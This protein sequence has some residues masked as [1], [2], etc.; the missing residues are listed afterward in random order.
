LFVRINEAAKLRFLCEIGCFSAKFPVFSFRF[1]FFVILQPQN[2]GKGMKNLCNILNINKLS[3]NSGGVNLL[4]E[5]S[6]TLSPRQAGM[7][8]FG[9]FFVPGGQTP[10]IFESLNLKSLNNTKSLN[11]N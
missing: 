2:R 4:S 1:V 11:L 3:K 9:F 6:H 10:Q 7:A 5:F 8:C